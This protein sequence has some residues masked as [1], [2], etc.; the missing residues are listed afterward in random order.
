[1]SPWLSGHHGCH[2]HHG[3]LG[4][5][6]HHGYH[7]QNGLHGHHRREDRQENQDNQAKTGQ[8]GH[9]GLTVKLDFPGKLCRAAFAFQSSFEIRVF[10]RSKICTQLTIYVIC[11]HRFRGVQLS[12]GS[13]DFFIHCFII[14][15]NTASKPFIS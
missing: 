12:M 15:Y 8:T 7:G 6:G 13:A 10:Q 3:R 1:M 5:H 9:T 14:N 4:C 11:I 2:R